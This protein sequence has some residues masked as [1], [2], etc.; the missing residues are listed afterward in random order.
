MERGKVTLLLTRP[1]AASRR[2]EEDMRPRLGP[3][4]TV[5][6]SPL[7]AIAARP[8]I[9]DFAGIKGLIF[10]SANGVRALNGRLPDL[11]IYAVGAMTGA[12]IE[13]EGRFPSAVFQDAD[14]LVRG[15]T[16]LEPASP[17]L[18]IRGQYAQGDVAAR[19]TDAGIPVR[20]HV[21][22][23]QPAL[24]FAKLALQALNGSAPVVAPVF[25]ARTAKEFVAQGP[26]SAPLFLGAISQPV[27]QELQALH[28][29]RLVVAETPDGPGMADATARLVAAAAQLED[30]EPRK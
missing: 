28:P 18:H 15:V 23:D 20:E 27:A 12:A 19:L 10:T 29:E 14:A 16:E 26:F 8:E 13:A 7:I 25:S 2:F 4:V 5:I 21:A 6:V 30:P 1:E 11:P 9:P 24:P 17:L 22:Y 3:D